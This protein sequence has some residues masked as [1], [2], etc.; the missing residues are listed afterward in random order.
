VA[1]IRVFGVEGTFP[2]DRLLLGVLSGP[3]VG[4]PEAAGLGG[5]GHCGSGFGVAVEKGA[6]D[7]CSSADCGDGD[8]CGH[9]RRLR[10]LRQPPGLDEQELAQRLLALGYLVCFLARQEPAAAG[11]VGV[12]GHEGDINPKLVM[13]KLC[14]GME[15]FVRTPDGRTLAVEDA[16]TRPCRSTTASGS[17]PGSR[18]RTAP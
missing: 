14:G 18:L 2:P 9:I 17:P 4:S 16:G 5:V 10:H 11:V 1:L 3:V 13:D 8:L 15:W 12:T 7:P 6:G